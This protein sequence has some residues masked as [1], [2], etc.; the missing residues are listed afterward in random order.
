[1]AAGREVVFNPT[2]IRIGQ[3]LPI[4]F[5]DLWRDFLLMFFALHWAAFEFAGAGQ[6]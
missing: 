1:M 5:K 6:A 3:V 4:A 2:F